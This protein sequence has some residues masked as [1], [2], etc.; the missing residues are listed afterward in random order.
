MKNL[1]KAVFVDHI[2]LCGSASKQSTFLFQKS[3]QNKEICKLLQ[4]KLF[5]G[6]HCTSANQHKI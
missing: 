5:K 2:S 3:N 1:L 4:R 6:T